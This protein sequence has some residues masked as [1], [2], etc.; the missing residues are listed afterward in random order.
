MVATRTDPCFGCNKV[1]SIE[2]DFEDHVAGTEFDLSIGVVSSIIEKM[3]GGSNGGFSS[4]NGGGGNVIECMEHGVVNGAGIK[5]EFSGDALDEFD[6]LWLEE[7]YVVKWSILDLCVSR[8][9]WVD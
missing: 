1:G 3:F 7:G 8:N 9:S 4:V 5:K 2:F 6:C